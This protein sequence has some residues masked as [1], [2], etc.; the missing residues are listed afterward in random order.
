MS[1]PISSV[2]PPLPI[3]PIPSLV[4]GLADFRVD[5]REEGVIGAFAGL[6]IGA[7]IGEMSTV[8]S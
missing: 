8:S 7:L 5:G 1:A 4:E 2:L 3:V 6:N